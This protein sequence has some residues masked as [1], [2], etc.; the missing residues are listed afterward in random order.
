MQ[1]IS[2]FFK[3][4]Y[5]SLGM[6]TAIPL[7]R[8]I[9]DEKLI[10][11][12][13][14]GFPLV[15]L[16]VGAIWWLAALLITT[17]S[18]PTMLTAAV[19]CLAPFLIAGFIHLDGY[20]DTSDAVLSR[21]EPDDKLRILLDSRV[22]AFAVIMLAILFILQFSAMYVIAENGKFFAL[23]IVISTLS[24]CCAAFSFF[25]L[26]HN[27]KSDFVLMFKQKISASYKIFVVIIA[28]L[29]TGASFLYAG[30][31]GLAVSAVVILGY[32][33]AIWRSS[34]SLGGISGDL[35]GYALVISELFGL[36]AFAVLYGAFW[37]LGIRS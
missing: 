22:G 2:N 19:L 32:L 33:L 25:C 34:K 30:F 12:M 10:F 27:S 6:F 20:M 5:M 16:I 26:R 8:K 3:G 9:W 18:V 23:L 14:I 17:L 31:L 37:E 36:V 1:S 11:H 24:R 35:L 13:L 29:A 4:F 7:P 15:G 21:R 28:V